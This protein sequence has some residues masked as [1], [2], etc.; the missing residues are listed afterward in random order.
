MHG[1][2]AAVIRAYILRARHERWKKVQTEREKGKAWAF[3]DILAAEGKQAYSYVRKY[4]RSTL[5]AI[6][7]ASTATR[8]ENTF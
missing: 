8:R 7:E 1:I 2:D 5:P 4:I 3:S 6:F